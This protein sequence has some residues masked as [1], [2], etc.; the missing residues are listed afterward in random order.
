MNY[1]EIISRMTNLNEIIPF[2]N[3]LLESTS[4]DDAS[5]NG[6][7]VESPE[8]TISK[9]ALSV[10]SGLSIIER[11]VS[12]QAQLLIVHH[13]LFWGD[14]RSISGVLAKKITL[15]IQSRCSLYASHLP[16]D[17]HQQVGNGSELARF[18]GAIDIKPFCEYRGKLIGAQGSFEKL[19]S[20][21]EITE[22][23]RNIPHS[24]G[25]TILPFG[26]K[27]IKN[28][29]IVTGSGAFAITKCKEEGL[30][31]LVSG[32]PKH[33]AYH[34]AKELGI[35]AIFA[36]HY[37]TETFGVLALGRELRNKYGVETIFL[38]EETGI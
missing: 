3:T 32:E 10:D 12:E 24:K 15:L 20:I 28:I 35:N 21:D 25:L 36:G 38:N 23:C 22:K 11:A 16:L 17:A 33:E 27:E 8:T 26:K 13:G 4:F 14:I 2:L 5:S 9:V 30:D 37:A 1:I 31:L 6:L 29:G 19:T 18:L 34:L 7:Q